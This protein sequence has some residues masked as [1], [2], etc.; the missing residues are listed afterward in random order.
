[1][2]RNSVRKSRYRQAGFIPLGLLYVIVLTVA[3]GLVGLK[4]VP[5]YLEHYKVKTALES[6]KKEPTLSSRSRD[7]ILTM[8]LKRLDVDMVEHVTAKE[9]KVEKRGQAIRILI[10]YDVVQ[11]MVGNVDVVL[12]FSDYLAVGSD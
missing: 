9:I 4:L 3:V 2:T 10:E 7:E 6:L 11:P 12:H 8:L 5:T 1:M